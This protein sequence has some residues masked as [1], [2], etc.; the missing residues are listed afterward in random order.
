MGVG[1]DDGEFFLA[2][3]MAHAIH[4]VPVHHARGIGL[5]VTKPEEMAQL[6]GQRPPGLGQVRPGHAG[7]QIRAPDTHETRRLDRPASVKGSAEFLDEG[8]ACFS[9]FEALRADPARD[10]LEIDLVDHS[11]LDTGPHG[12]HI[13]LTRQLEVDLGWAEI[14]APVHSPSP[15]NSRPGSHEVYG[16][17]N[18]SQ[19][20]SQSGSS[21]PA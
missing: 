10:R 12:N 7:G 6:M 11:A 15:Q 1:L 17:Q 21:Q 20:P 9:P 3:G 13:D 19:I 5:V 18:G 16:K 8:Q 14:F 4:P 2:D